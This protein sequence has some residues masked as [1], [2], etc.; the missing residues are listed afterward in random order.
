[1]ESLLLAGVHP[2]ACAIFPQL[3]LAVSYFN[4]STNRPRCK[5]T[6]HPVG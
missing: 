5:P 6:V 4:V 1:M 3:S 2:K